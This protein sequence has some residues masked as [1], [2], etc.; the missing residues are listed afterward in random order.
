MAG[1]PDHPDIVSAMATGYSCAQVREMDKLPK[2]ICTDC[3]E[4]FY[5]GEQY[6]EDGT[7]RYHCEVCLQDM[8]LD[9]LLDT[10]GVKLEVFGYGDD[11]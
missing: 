9:E 4:Q 6:Y 8:S 1:L 3:K 10:F 5:K 11:L 7:G 2:V